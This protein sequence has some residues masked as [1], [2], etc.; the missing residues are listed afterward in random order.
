MTRVKQ[1]T[2]LAFLTL[3]SGKAQSHPHSFIAMQ[4]EL[5]ASAGSLTAVNMRWTMDEITS[6]DLLYDA[7]N[8]KPGDEVWK[9]LAAEVMANVL[10]QHYFTEFWHGKQ[11]VK[12]ANRPTAYGLSRDGHKAVLTFTL[13]LAE[14]QPLAGQRYTFSTF[15]PSYFV[16]MHY[17]HDADVKLGADFPPGCALKVFTPQ[18]SDSLTAYALSLN[19]ADA[20]PE[21]MDL[22]K[23]FAQQ[24]TL[25]CQ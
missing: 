4:G 24:V 6:A 7:G 10:G 1:I 25:S 22:G 19:K 3:L 15:D 21:D 20:P 8:A 5:I 18:P 23:Q 12:F 11:K 14:P 16:D 13:P 17:D 2:A 9:K